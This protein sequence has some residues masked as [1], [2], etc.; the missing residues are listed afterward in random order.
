MTK[1]KLSDI[2]KGRAYFDFY[3]DG[4]LWYSVSYQPEGYDFFNCCPTF[5]FSVPVSDTGTGT[6][7]SA[8]KAMFFMRWIRPAVIAYNEAIENQQ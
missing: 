8:D 1:L 4:Q 7:L 5:R 6:F 3:R 2:V